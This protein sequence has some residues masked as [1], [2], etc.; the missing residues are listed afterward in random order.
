ML[1][2]VGECKIVCPDNCFG[3]P[4]TVS[5]SVKNILIARS[6]FNQD[7]APFKELVCLFVITAE[8]TW[9]VVVE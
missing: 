7:L 1:V 4:P 3:I 9:T 6:L 5:T 8:K 2:C